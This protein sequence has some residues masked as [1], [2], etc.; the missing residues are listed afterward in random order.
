MIDRTL[1]SLFVGIFGLMATLYV[2]HNIMNLATAYGAVGAVIS[3]ENNAIFTNNLLPAIGTGVVPIF[4]WLIFLFEIATGLVCL[5]GAWKLW[6]SRS[7]EAS[8]FEAAKGPA[9]LGLGLGVLTWFG[10]FGTF[11]GAGYQ[12]WQH[13]IG[14]GSLSDAYKFSVWALLLLFY[15]SQRE[16]EA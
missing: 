2:I 3:L 16:V 12:M 11:G 1:K 6:E 4:A 7:K 15:V 13:E 14:A 5:W 10:L 9:K 8:I